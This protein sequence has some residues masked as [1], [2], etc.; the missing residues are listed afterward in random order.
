MLSNRQDVAMARGGRAAM[1]PRAGSPNREVGEVQRQGFGVQEFLDGS[2][3]EGDFVDGLKHGKGRYSW[4]NGEFYEGSFYK[5]YRHGDGMY[6]W[7]TGNKFMGKFYLNWREGYGQHLFSDGAT[8]KGLYHA[9][10]SFSLKNLTEYAAYLEPNI[11]SHSHGQVEPDESW[12][13]HDRNNALP[14]GIENYSTDGDHLPLPPG[15]RREF[16]RHFFEQL[17]E[18]DW[19]SYEGYKRD[20]HDNLPL[21]A[22]MLA[23]I[24]KHRKQA[25][26]LDWDVAAIISMERDRFGPKGNLEITSELLIH[27]ASVGKGAAILSIL[28]DGLVHPDVADSQGHTALIA[29]TVNCHNDVV[30]LLLDLGADID[31]VNSEGMSALAVCHVL[32]YPFQ[33]LYTFDGLISKTQ[34]STYVVVRIQSQ[35]DFP[36]C[37]IDFPP[38]QIGFPPCQIGFPPCQIDFPPCQIALPPCQIDFPPCQIDFPP[39]QIDFPPCQ[40][41]LPPCQID[42]PPWLSLSDG[43]EYIEMMPPLHQMETAQYLFPLQMAS[44]SICHQIRQVESTKRSPNSKKGRG[45]VR[46]RRDD[47]KV[48]GGGDKIREYHEVEGGRDKDDKAAN[49]EKVLLSERSVEVKE[50]HIVLGSVKWKEYSSKIAKQESNKNMKPARC[51]DSACCMYS[52]SIHVSENVLQEAAEALSHAWFQQ[53]SDDTEETVRKMAAMKFEHR[54]RLTTLNL[55]LDRGADPNTSRVPLPVIFL[56]ILAADTKTVKKHLLC[57]AQTDICLPPERKGL[58]PLHVAAALPGLEGPEIT[59]LLLHALTHPD[60]RACDQDDIY[61]PDKGSTITRKSWRMDEKPRPKEGG[62]T[63]LHIACQRDSDYC[64]ASKVVSL[65]LSYNASTDFLW[66]GHSPLSLA[67]ASGNNTAVEELLKGGVDPNLT[68]GRGVGTALCALGNF[69]YRLD[70]NRPKLLDMLEKVGADI[71]MPVQVGDTVGTAVDY[72]HVSFN[73]DSGIAHTP[74]H[75]LSMEGREMFKIQRQLL[76]MMGSLLKK[77]VVQRER[78]HLVR[79]DKGAIYFDAKMEPPTG[80]KLRSP[81][82]FCYQCGRSAAVKLTACTRCHKVFYCSMACKLIAWDERHKEECLRETGSAPV[83][84]EKRVMFQTKKGPKTVIFAT[85]R[86]YHAQFIEDNIVEWPSISVNENYSYN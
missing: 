17:W 64:N 78:E 15:R 8:F 86:P 80:L 37:Q 31:K 40:I 46:T 26:T 72:A 54:V 50:G 35:I 68:L 58:Y 44:A 16:D 52:Y 69:N 13:L 32:Y 19:H 53:H 43:K 71:L 18:P 14:C 48:E 3:Y 65:L 24:H 36:P 33:S 57:G 10:Q 29:A 56:A 27:Q 39:C 45:K 12:L 83:T 5:D 76:S 2:K 51:F 66:S 4:Q 30:Q 22:R 6:C 21:R 81:F 75:A 20:P 41:D 28:L 84:F 82:K 9:D 67:I 55:L 7:P 79:I 25:E 70:A 60:A 73:Q 77:T 11:L 85:R 61:Q 47:S 34:V 42:F 62:R 49:E 23:H 63:A 38:C 59:K 74:Y 1:K